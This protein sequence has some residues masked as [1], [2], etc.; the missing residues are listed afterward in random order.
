VRSGAML[1]A[2]SYYWRLFAT[3]LCFTVFGL[4]AAI[5]GMLVFPLMRL[6]PGS[7]ATHRRRVRA[8]FRVYMRSFV[9]FMSAVGVLS[10]EFSGAERLGRPGQIILAN[11]PSLIDVVFLIG[12]T[13]Q[14][15]CVVKEALFHNPITRWPVAAAGYVSNTSTHSMVERAS[16]AL[17]EGQNVIVFPEGT[18]TTPGQPMQFHR[19]AASIAVRAAEVVTPVFIRCEPTT[20]AKNMPWYRIPDRRVRFSF[21]VGADIDLAPFRTQPGPLASRAFNT[22][23]LKLFAAELQS[24]EPAPAESRAGETPAT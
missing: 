15:T 14:A 22:H 11:H 7:E 10:Y 1:K 17:R 23:L 24:D 9:G 18:R 8:T 13:P 5:F 21:R 6:A 20:L 4:G 16:D 3:G 2:T 19:G 12:F